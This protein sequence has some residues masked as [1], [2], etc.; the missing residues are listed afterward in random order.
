MS[1]ETPSTE[2]A[3]T[4]VTPAVTEED[5]AAIVDQ[6]LDSMDFEPELLNLSVADLEEK[7]SLMI[8]DMDS[9]PTF[10]FWGS[11]IRFA[12]PVVEGLIKRKVLKDQ[13]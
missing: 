10:S 7:K 3:D 12:L 4:E 9:H 8:K 1:E 2:E 11:I 13:A 6:A 5:H